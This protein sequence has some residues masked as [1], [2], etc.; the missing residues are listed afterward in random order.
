MED[1]ESLER[2]RSCL[3]VL[4]GLYP[5]L[6][7]R[8]RQM[9]IALER[10]HLLSRWRIGMQVRRARCWSVGGNDARWKSH[11]QGPCDARSQ[12]PAEGEC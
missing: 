3:S 12:I 11:A 6:R 1:V 2:E 4:H 9:G 10:E 5:A 7:H 8:Q